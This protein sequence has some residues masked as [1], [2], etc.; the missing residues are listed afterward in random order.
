MLT[1]SSSSKWNRADYDDWNADLVSKVTAVAAA[2][3]AAKEAAGEGE[4]TPAA[5]AAVVIAVGVGR[6]DKLDA[7]VDLLS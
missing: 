4:S 6:R 5:R 2:A 7:V 1:V 3:A